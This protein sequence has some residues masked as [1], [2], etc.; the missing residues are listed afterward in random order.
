MTNETK[1]CLKSSYLWR[2]VIKLE[3]KTNMSVHLL[4]DVPTIQ[5]VQWLLILG[6]KKAPVKLANG[7]I[8]ILDKFC[9]VI[10]S[11]KVLKNT[12]FP[13]I[14]NY[15]NDYKRLYERTLLTP[16][17]NS[18]NAINLRIQNELLEQVNLTNRLM[19]L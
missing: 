19:Q 18:V 2:Y 3:L 1:T 9:T 16:K 15:F 11:M 17:S 13:N 6:D 7:L 4:G 12:A 8:N 10:E 5:F 14:R